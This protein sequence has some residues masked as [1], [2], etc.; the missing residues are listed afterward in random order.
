MMARMTLTLDAV[1][2][3]DDAQSWAATGFA[4]DGGG[5][6]R[7]GGVDLRLLG[8][9]AGTGLVGWALGGLPADIADV[10]GIPT[11]R[12]A[13]RTGG[14]APGHPNGSVGIDHVVVFS[15]HLTRTVAALSDLGAAPRRQR[16]AQLGG[17]PIRQVFVRFGEV[18]VEVVGAPD[19]EGG[20][21]STLW[22]VTFTVA[23]IDATAAFLGGRTSSVKDAVQPGRRITTLRH[24]DCGMSVRVAFLSAGR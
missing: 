1:D 14:S 16:D 8:G 23:D 18:I 5:V 17:N 22:G 21:P 15:P 11:T 9:T 12:S 24:R 10:D 3:A 4:V 19:A 7:V 2:V 13:G 20:G 6:C